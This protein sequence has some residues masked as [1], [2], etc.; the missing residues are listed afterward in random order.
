MDQSGPI[1]RGDDGFEGHW[2]E[3]RKLVVSEIARL[4]KES[5]QH[6][7]NRN[8]DREEI[9]ILKTKAA[10][11]GGIMGA[12]AGGC[13]TAIIELIVKAFSK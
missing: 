10:M 5:E 13:L 12:V 11:L 4:S 6:Y 9:V 2:V 1:L 7:Q 8:D 3:Y